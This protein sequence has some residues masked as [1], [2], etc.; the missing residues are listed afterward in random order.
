MKRYVPD[1]LQGK[2]KQEKQYF[3]YGAQY[4][5]THQYHDIFRTDGNYYKSFIVSQK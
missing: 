2:A 4:Y 5:W 1:M 3:M